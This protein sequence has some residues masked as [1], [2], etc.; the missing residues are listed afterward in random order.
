MI[1]KI[2]E[3]Y[4]LEFGSGDIHIRSGWYVPAR[5]KNRCGLVAFKNYDKPMLIGLQ[6]T[7]SEE[8]ELWRYPI[9]MTFS[10]PES[11]DALIAELQ[12][13]RDEMTKYDNDGYLA[14][15]EKTW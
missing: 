15:L 2:G 4:H 8:I 1:K 7:I 13:A 11:I 9:Y 10:K 6:N 14:E 3:Q 5:E 12:N